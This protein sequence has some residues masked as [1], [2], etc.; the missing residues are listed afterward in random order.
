MS[1]ILWGK[2][3]VTKIQNRYITLIQWTHNT[4]S[5]KSVNRFVLFFIN[6]KHFMAHICAKCRVH[7]SLNDYLFGNH[8]DCSGF[9]FTSLPIKW[10]HENPFSHLGLAVLRVEYANGRYCQTVV[11]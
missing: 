2:G 6:R 10:T 11:T 7:L 3:D 9:L 8:G 1:C 5:R 4:R